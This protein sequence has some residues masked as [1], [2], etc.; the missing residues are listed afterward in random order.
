ML[1]PAR[2]ATGLGDKSVDVDFD[3]HG[4]DL[5]PRADRLARRPLFARGRPT[6]RP[7][8]MGAHGGYLG[9]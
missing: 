4:P 9:R 8:A 5:D 1:M 7:F 6:G 3:P 2:P